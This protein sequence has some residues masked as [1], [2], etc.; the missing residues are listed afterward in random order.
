MKLVFRDF[1]GGV[2]ESDES[3]V[4]IDG[5]PAEIRTEQLPNKSQQQYR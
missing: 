5:I 4:R 1:I 3:S 2:E